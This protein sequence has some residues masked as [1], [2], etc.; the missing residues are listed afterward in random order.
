MRQKTT[1]NLFCAPRFLV[2]INDWM[3]VVIC[4]LFV[5]SSASFPAPLIINKQWMHLRKTPE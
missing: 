2:I 3:D 5:S 1:H 4:T